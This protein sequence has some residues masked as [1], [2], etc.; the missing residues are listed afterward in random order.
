MLIKAWFLQL[1]TT[2]GLPKGHRPRPRQDGWGPPEGSGGGNLHQKLP[3]IKRPHLTPQEHQLESKAGKNNSRTLGVPADVTNGDFKA[4][5]K[6]Q[7]LAVQV[8]GAKD[9]P[10]TEAK[11]CD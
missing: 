1:S 8:T 5:C 9:A 10:E 6:C 2:P 11:A 3:G 4:F 7:Q